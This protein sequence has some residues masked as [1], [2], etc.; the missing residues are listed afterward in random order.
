M[1]L[2]PRLC[3]EAESERSRRSF[4]IQDSGLS[5]Q[6]PCKANEQTLI[7]LTA[8]ER[9]QV[10]SRCCH[11]GVT[12]LEFGN[13]SRTRRSPANH[14]ENSES[15]KHLLHYLPSSLQE[16]AVGFH[17]VSFVGYGREP[18][19]EVYLL[20]IPNL[21]ELH[22]ARQCRAAPHSSRLPD[23]KPQGGFTL[24]YTRNPKLLKALNSQNCSGHFFP[25]SVPGSRHRS[26]PQFLLFSWVAYY[27][28]FRLNV[29]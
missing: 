28:G 26:G 24:S 1:S 27:L 20:G 6:R 19:L 11:S 9:L 12:S 3:C 29:P 13:Q 4:G 23:P 25:G 17:G 22:H 7:L 16:W 10:A 18:I 21:R 2:A 8:T 15:T 14:R 5:S